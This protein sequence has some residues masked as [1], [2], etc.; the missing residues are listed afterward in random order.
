MSRNTRK[1]LKASGKMPELAFIFGVMLW[2]TREI[3]RK[4]WQN[5]LRTVSINLRLSWLCLMG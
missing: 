4:T 2:E 1:L 5:T 3:K